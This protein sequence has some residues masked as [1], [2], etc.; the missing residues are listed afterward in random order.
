[1]ANYFYPA[2]LKGLRERGTLRDIQRREL[3]GYIRLLPNQKRVKT[4]GEY[5]PDPDMM[6]G[7]EWKGGSPIVEPEE[8]EYSG[9]GMDIDAPYLIH[10]CGRLERLDLGTWSEFDWVDRGEGHF[11]WTPEEHVLFRKRKLSRLLSGEKMVFR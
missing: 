4:V 3:L 6:E 1:M 10:L 11:W 5:K 7:M 2:Y 9:E 8:W